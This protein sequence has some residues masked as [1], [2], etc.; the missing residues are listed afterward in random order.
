MEKLE[1][2]KILVSTIIME[3]MERI[4][5]REIEERAERLKLEFRLGEHG[6]SGIPGKSA[7][8]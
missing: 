3:V 8:G 4:A 1:E 2:Q 6:N 5:N 7:V